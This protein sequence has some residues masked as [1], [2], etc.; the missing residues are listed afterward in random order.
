MSKHKELDIE[1]VESFAV[2]ALDS[3]RG[4]E[5]AALSLDSNASGDALRELFRTA[6]TLKGSA[7]GI[8]LDEYGFFV[9]K[10]E[11]LIQ[12]LCMGEI[13]PA[14]DVVDTLL[15]AHARLKAWA[16]GLS[17]N[18]RHIAP[19]DD[20]LAKLAAIQR[21]AQSGSDN[22]V[23]ATRS[24]PATKVETSESLE[25]VLDFYK[26]EAQ[27]PETSRRSRKHKGAGNDRARRH[28][29]LDH[30]YQSLKV[31]TAKLDEII[32]LVGEIS[33]HQEILK[34]VSNDEASR[35]R[36]AQAVQALTLRLMHELHSTG[37]GARRVAIKSLMLKLQKTATLLAESQGKKVRVVLEGEDVELN[38]L[39][40]EKLS[41]PLVHVIRN[42]VDH[43]VEYSDARVAQGKAPEATITIRA[44]HDAHDISVSVTDDGQGLN[45]QAIFSA[46]VKKGLVR[47]DEQLS[48]EQI[49]QFIFEQGF[50]TASRLTEVSGRGV[51]MD[52]ALKAVQ[53]LHG[54]ITLSSEPGR[55]TTVSIRIP[56]PRSGGYDW[57]AL[58]AQMKR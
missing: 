22:D 56:E 30:A 7:M 52:V 44:R 38:S 12:L 47:S 57:S 46:A 28:K 23:A 41:A 25:V 21:P 40:Y 19:V 54:V 17:T 48:P 2:D 31:S 24:K 18:A 6:H 13:S 51:G 15:C 8:G 11:D 58:D 16:Q 45:D 4:F 32:D 37:G 49:R 14:P 26:K 35:D 43:G 33:S 55:G 29:K 34:D 36:S 20:V 39:V 1:L 27:Q 42:A 3:L 53:E 50:S 9:H 5:R 10:V